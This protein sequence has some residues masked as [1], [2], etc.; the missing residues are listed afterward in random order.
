MILVEAGAFCVV[1][2]VHQ[3]MLQVPNVE[4]CQ[5]KRVHLAQAFV[6]KAHNE[7]AVIDGFLAL[8]IAS[9]QP[10]TIR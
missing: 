1:I 9:V 10:D 8:L 2:S 5:A 6:T 4:N 7:S 3:E